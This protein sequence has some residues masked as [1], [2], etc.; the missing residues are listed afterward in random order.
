[1]TKYRLIRI[2]GMLAFLCLLVAI[3]SGMF[4][5]DFRIHISAAIA[6]LVFA[7][8][9]VIAVHVPFKQRRKA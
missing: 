3:G 4:S 9:H 7:L 1:M 5:L 8:V 6:M 2:S